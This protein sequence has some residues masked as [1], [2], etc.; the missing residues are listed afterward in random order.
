MGHDASCRQADEKGWKRETNA[1]YLIMFVLVK[2]GSDGACCG[3]FFKIQI[4]L[5]LCHVWLL[6]WTQ[7]SPADT[8]RD[9]VAVRSH[10]SV[11]RLPHSAY[12]EWWNIRWYR[13]KQSCTAH[14]DLCIGSLRQICM[15]ESVDN[16]IEVQRLYPR[17]WRR[18]F[19]VKLIVFTS[20]E[21]ISWNIQTNSLLQSSAT[22]QFMLCPWKKVK[23]TGFHH[24]LQKLPLCSRHNPVCSSWGYFKRRIKNVL[25]GTYCC[26]R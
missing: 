8:S 16:R 3:W 20:V 5:M 1:K 25:K 2:K 26:E 22:M 4:G 11:S 15:L 13:S 14:T 19:R 23:N 17:A 7:S 10:S 6:C 9:G 12:V 21:C 18:S 24:L